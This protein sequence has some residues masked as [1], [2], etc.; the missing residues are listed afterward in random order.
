MTDRARIQTLETTGVVGQIPVRLD[1]APGVEW[2]TFT[3][4]TAEALGT[5]G[6]DVDVGSSAPPSAGDVLTA[7]DA[8]HATWQAPTSGPV[9]DG[10]YGDITVS[11]TGTVWTLDL[12]LATIDAPTASVGFAQQQATQF[13][14]ENRTSDPGSP[15]VGEIWLRT[16]L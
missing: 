4:G 13:R 5:T 14:I 6:A 11:S 7:V 8:T 2:Q 12:N 3:A 1:V 10:D 16:D 9:A 15:A